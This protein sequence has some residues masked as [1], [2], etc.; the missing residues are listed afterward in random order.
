MI[1]SATTNNEMQEDTKLISMDIN[2]TCPCCGQKYV[3]P[4]AYATQKFRCICGNRARARKLTRKE[5]MA[6]ILEITAPFLV[7]IAGILLLILTALT[8]H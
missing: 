6:N 4:A 2:Y 3:I 5:K 8:G 1:S 7:A